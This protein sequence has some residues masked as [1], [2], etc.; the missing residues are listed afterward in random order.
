MISLTSNALKVRLVLDAVDMRK[1]FNGL[2][3]AIRSIHEAEP[4]PRYVYVFSNKRRNRVK[5]LYYDRSGVW[6]AAKR[7]E[8]GSFSW[9]ATSG[10]NEVVMPLAAEALQLLIDGVDLRDAKLREWYRDPR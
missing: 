8:E 7:L 6:V 5:I 2:T 4:D 3:G 9:P 1:S 10:K